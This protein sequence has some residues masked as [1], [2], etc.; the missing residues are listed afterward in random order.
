MLNCGKLT[1]A[2]FY[3]ESAQ[4]PSQSAEDQCFYQAYNVE[5]L[6]TFQA[7]A[8]N[9]EEDGDA[10]VDGHGQSEEEE[11]QAVSQA[12]AVVDVGLIQFFNTA[13]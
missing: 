6:P 10:A 8:V 4:E 2:K 5:H 13:Q 9:G 1:L 7:D 11:P 12:H 3:R